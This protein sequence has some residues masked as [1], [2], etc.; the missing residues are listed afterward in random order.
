MEP[1]WKE[2]MTTL[3]HGTSGSRTLLFRLDIGLSE[4]QRE[5]LNVYADVNPKDAAFEF[6]RR[7]DLPEEI[8]QKLAT[9]IEER[10][11]L[12]YADKGHTTDEKQQQQSHKQVEQQENAAENSTRNVKPPEIPGQTSHAP[13]S[14]NSNRSAV[15]MHEAN[16][17][18]SQKLGADDDMFDE[19]RLIQSMGSLHEAST[20]HPLE[21]SDD[22]SVERS[23]LH[24]LSQRS[25][26]L[27]ESVTDNMSVSNGSSKIEA[28][29]QHQLSGSNVQTSNKETTEGAVPAEPEAS[30]HTPA[31]TGGMEGKHE[32]GYQDVQD[33]APRHVTPKTIL[34]LRDIGMTNQQMTTV[35]KKHVNESYLMCS[36]EKNSVTLFPPSINLKDPSTD[37]LCDTIL[38][39][40]LQVL[41]LSRNSLRGVSLKSFP[42]LTTVYLNHNHIADLSGLQYC[43]RLS[44]LFVASNK[45][46][47]VFGLESLSNLKVLDISCNQIDSLDGINSLGMNS[48]LHTLRMHGNPI[49][50]KLRPARYRA[51]VLQKLP[52]LKTLDGFA[53]QDEEMDYNSEGTNQVSGNVNNTE[54]IH[55]K[56]KPHEEFSNQNRVHHFTDIPRSRAQT[57]AELPE[58][59]LAQTIA[60]CTPHKLIYNDG[61]Q[62]RNISRPKERDLAETVIKSASH[63]RSTSVPSRSP[64]EASSRKSNSY[65]AQFVES[66]RMNTPPTGHSF[67]M[68]G[69]LRSHRTRSLS[70]TLQ[71]QKDRERVRGMSPRQA[72][73]DQVKQEMDPALLSRITEAQLQENHQKQQQQKDRATPR[74]TRSRAPRFRTHQRSISRSRFYSDPQCNDEN[75]PPF[76]KP[77]DDLDTP[78]NMMKVW[79]SSLRSQAKRP[80]SA[81]NHRRRDA[82][83]RGKRYSNSDLFQDFRSNLFTDT[84]KTGAYMPDSRKYSE[85]SQG[86]PVQDIIKALIAGK[87]AA[88]ERLQKRRNSTKSDRQRTDRN[89]LSNSSSGVT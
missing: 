40:N 55:G 58:R 83:P 26:V 42:C 14:T 36:L 41:N 37:V 69:S 2:T 21:E 80:T 78:A 24:K 73:I 18:S 46:E 28:E 44:H 57:S 23:L 16:S 19:K 88:L 62:A 82:T 33:E 17:T 4:N 61:A 70:A 6:A 12:H 65:V 71:A 43:E 84:K 75:L 87:K 29:G 51:L 45:L 7:H 89:Y 13:D 1:V 30:V 47:D 10:L 81:R 86:Q 50:N 76:R 53:R 3:S 54:H 60:S 20:G 5:I 22:D 11:R 64:M 68:S 79:R 72:R 77:F 27:N 35:L 8:E 59:K 32:S 85:P 34:D 74:R 48:N 67:S 66:R 31:Q 9:M 39:K 49:C 15:H 56:E 63:N 38:S 52:Q 25:N